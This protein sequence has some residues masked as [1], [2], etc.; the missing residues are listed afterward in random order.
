MSCLTS[1]GLCIIEH[2]PVHA[3]RPLNELDPFGADLY[4]MP[5]LIAKWGKGRYGIR[6]ILEAPEKTRNDKL[7]SFIVIQRFAE[8]S[9]EHSATVGVPANEQSRKEP[10]V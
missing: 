6:E 1:R 8:N 7:S 9:S 2:N 4:V 5:Y 10:Q 3:P